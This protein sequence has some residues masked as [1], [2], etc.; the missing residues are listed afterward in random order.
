MTG[1]SWNLD[2]PPG[3]R[4]LDPERP[5]TAYHRH[6]PHWRQDGATYFVTYRLADSLPQTK[7]RE[8]DAW[9]REW[10]SKHGLRWTDWTSIARS[11]LPREKWDEYARELMRKIERWLDEGLGDCWLK[12]SDLRKFAD[13]ALCHF[14]GERYELGC[15]VVMPNHAHAL[16]RPLHPAEYPLERVLQG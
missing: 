9:K 5:I 14:D 12:R 15:Y 7:L 8:L 13:D 6:L 10:L 1:E 16:I 11:G 2:P 4:G 3:F